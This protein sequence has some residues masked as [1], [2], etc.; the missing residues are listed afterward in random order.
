[1]NSITPAG[2]LSAGEIRKR[3]SAEDRSRLIVTPRL[4]PAVNDASVDL[5]LGNNFI[6]FER[7]N[8]GEFDALDDARDPRAIQTPVVREWGDVFFLHPG[9]LVLAATLEYLVLPD[10][11][12]GQ[13]ITRSSY[14]RLGLLSATAVQVHPGFAGCLTLEL[15]NLGELPMAITPGE[16]VA[17]LMLWQTEAPQSA[18]AATKKYTYPTGP[19]F[20]KIR[21]D[22]EADV[23]RRMRD[24][25]RTR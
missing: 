8:L 22:D 12:A 15:V 19:E 1:M 18:G 24:A 20:S 17:Q 4:P 21:G 10:D 9:Q 6:V 7:S 3:L 5:R 16:R 23:L 13:V 11:L 14:G 2:A 25:F